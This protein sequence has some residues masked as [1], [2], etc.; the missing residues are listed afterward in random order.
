M[1]A[2][3]WVCWGVPESSCCGVSE[4]EA[5]IPAKLLWDRNSCQ[6]HH[7]NTLL[8]SL[9]CTLP[10]A[11]HSFSYLCM[12]WEEEGKGER[13]EKSI[14]LFQTKGEVPSGLCRVQEGLVLNSLSRNCRFL[15]NASCVWKRFFSVLLL[16]CYCCPR[17]KESILK[18]VGEG[19]W[20]SWNSNR[21]TAT[22]HTIGN[23]KEL[24]GAVFPLVSCTSKTLTPLSGGGFRV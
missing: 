3:C 21:N 16:W 12:K 17:P 7:P 6:R 23:S 20:M 2:V 24:R 15:I 9:C 19:E 22:C 5:G 8:A 14:S 13:Q 11:I 18:F 1:T 4:G 10:G